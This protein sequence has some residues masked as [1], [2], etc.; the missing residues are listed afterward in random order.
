MFVQRQSRQGTGT[1]LLL[2]PGRSQEFTG[3]KDEKHI[4]R[5]ITWDSGTAQRG[6]L[7]KT[8]EL[9]IAVVKQ[10][11]SASRGTDTIK[12]QV[13][14]LPLFSTCTFSSVPFIFLVPPSEILRTRC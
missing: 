4:Y 7:G 14:L 12:S 13:L 2:L 1:D 11:R 3:K 9:R 6:A 8:G 5:K 10:S